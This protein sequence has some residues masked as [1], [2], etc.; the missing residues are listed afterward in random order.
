MAIQTIAVKQQ[1]HYENNIVSQ[2]EII[3]IKPAENTLAANRS[4][5]KE[6]TQSFSINSKNA[7][8]KSQI[9]APD[10]G[11]TQSND[12]TELYQRPLPPKVK[13]IKL[14]LESYLGKDLSIDLSQLDFRNSK[15][16]SLADTEKLSDLNT[17]SNPKNEL[18]NIDGQQFNSDDNITVTNSNVELQYLSYQV[19]GQFSLNDQNITLD[20]QFDLSSKYAS[21]TTI[22]TTAAA[23]KDPLIIQFGAQGIGE[24]NG[25]TE[26]DINND[27]NLNSLPI[28]SG[29]VGYLVFDKNDNKTVDN[30]S[31]L[32]GPT[33]NNGFSEL[34]QLDSNNNGFFDSQDNAYQRVYIWQPQQDNS[35]NNTSNII[36]KKGNN[37]QQELVSLAHAGVSAIYLD[38]IDTPFNFRNQNGDITAQLRQSSFAIT[39]NNQAVGIHQIDVQI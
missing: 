37:N 24:I 7:L 26:L 9:M 25:E 22:T 27:K 23:L 18:L 4:P 3:A 16:Q 8:I 28:F 33:S 38:A 14:I 34:A 32:F 20:Y 13:L 19:Q 35:S 30:G 29:D 6:N 31:E 21:K 11:K 15:Q 10:S 5:I 12:E 39:D 36:P 1:Q 2:R 17:S